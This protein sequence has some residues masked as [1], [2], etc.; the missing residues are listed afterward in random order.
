MKNKISNDI[1]R[2]CLD[3]TKGDCPYMFR[4]EYEVPC[5]SIDGVIQVEWF[6]CTP[7]EVI[8]KQGK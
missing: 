4:N 7:I 6:G 3:K 2:N 8:K 5:C 1:Y